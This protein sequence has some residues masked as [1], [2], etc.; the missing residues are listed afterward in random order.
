MRIVKAYLTLESYIDTLF[1][2]LCDIY[3][4]TLKLT[5]P[6][7]Q[8]EYAVLICIPEDSKTPVPPT[9]LWKDTI[10]KQL[11]ISLIWWIE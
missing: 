3:I 1:L 2:I 7:N 4:H 10:Y 11:L 6:F 8:K 5:I 9:Y